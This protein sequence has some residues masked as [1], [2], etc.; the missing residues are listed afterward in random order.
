MKIKTIVKLLLIAGVYSTGLQM[1]HAQTMI[2]PTFQCMLTDKLDPDRWP[3]RQKDSFGRNDAKIYFI[4]DSDNAATGDRI[5]AVWQAVHTVDHMPSYE[6]I[7][8]KSLHVI[9]RPNG[10]E[11]IEADLSLAKPVD[12]WD[13]GHYQVQVYVNG[14]EGYVYKF[15]IR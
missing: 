10:G 1:S 2:L 9:K 12:G 3:G 14:I 4:C 11:M 5:K 8:V 7:G 6:T 15:V 13:I